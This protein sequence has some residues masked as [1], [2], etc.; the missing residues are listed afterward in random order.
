[1]CL[2]TNGEGNR[3]KNFILEGRGLI[4]GWDM[5]VTKLTELGIKG[6]REERRDVVGN[7]EL[8]ATQER[9]V[10]EDKNEGNL[11]WGRSFVEV[12]KEERNHS[13]NMIWVDAGECLP[14]EAMGTLKFCLVGR[15]ENPPDTYSTD[16]ELEAWA[17]TTW[18]LKGSLMVA[19]LNHDLQ[20][21]EFDISEEA[22]WV[23]ESGRRWFRGGSLNLGEVLSL[24]TCHLPIYSF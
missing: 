4:K 5:L 17:R 12:T 16:L 1:M 13:P 9:R 10:I 15:W 20:F 23:F 3:H 21:L 24:A 11:L 18:R 2:V 19:F 22:K 7:K 14:R 8:L 6:K